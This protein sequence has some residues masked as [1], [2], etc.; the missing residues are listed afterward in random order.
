[1]EG[2]RG[3][4]V[5]VRITGHAKIIN[6]NTMETYSID[7]VPYLNGKIKEAVIEVE[8]MNQAADAINEFIERNP[9]WDDLEQD[10]SF[11]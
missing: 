4:I 7:K 3:N 6:P 1:M 5:K 11:L 9:E 2:R 10:I 8:N